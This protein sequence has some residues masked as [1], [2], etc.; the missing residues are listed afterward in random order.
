MYY[1]FGGYMENSKQETMSAH[2][3]KRVRCIRLY[4]IK[5]DFIK[6]QQLTVGKEYEVELTNDKNCGTLPLVGLFG[7]FPNYCFEVLEWWPVK[8]CSPLTRPMC[9][10]ADGVPPFKSQ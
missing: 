3:E 5:Y 2:A 9:K 6:R 4:D 1:I 10:P 8:F 7:F